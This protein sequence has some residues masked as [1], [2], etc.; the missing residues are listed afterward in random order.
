MPK[1]KKGCRGLST[2]HAADEQQLLHW[3][4][5][6]RPNG[7]EITRW[8][9][10]IQAQRSFKDKHFK[11]SAGWRNNFINRRGL[12]LRAPTKISQKLPPELDDKIVNF[13]RH[14]IKL[15]QSYNYDLSCIT[16][17]DE[18]PVY[19]DLPGSRKMHPTAEKTVLVET[20]DNERSHFT[21]V[22]GVCAGCTKLK[23]MLIFKRKTAPKVQFPAGV[24][25]YVNEKG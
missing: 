3:V 17:M 13:H 5:Q 8:A 9:I 16:N 14:V 6:H 7:Y 2:P 22:L 1:K 10:R 24:V 18:F 12:S 11:A 15:R 19:F 4:I 21:A 23:P 25:V 20:V